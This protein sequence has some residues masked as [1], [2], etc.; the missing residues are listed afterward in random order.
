MSFSICN[1][2]DNYLFFLQVVLFSLSVSRDVR[3]PLVVS[4]HLVES[5]YEWFY[6]W[7]LSS[8]GIDSS[9]S[10]SWKCIYNLSPLVAYALIICLGRFIGIPDKFSIYIFRTVYL[11][12][13][14]DTPRGQGSTSLCVSWQETRLPLFRVFRK[15][16]GLRIAWQLVRRIGTPHD[17]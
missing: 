12:N 3:L 1:S 7:L 9:C 13:L 8:S 11:Q 10:S 14:H 2:R 16:L 4:S 15:R 5:Q 6:F 17:M